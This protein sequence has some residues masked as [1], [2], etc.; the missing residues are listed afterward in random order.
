M[1]NL[2][3]LAFIASF[4]SLKSQSID[5]Y[6]FQR[7]GGITNKNCHFQLSKDTFCILNIIN[8]ISSYSYNCI[9]LTNANT[10]EN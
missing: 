5:G 6:H 4:L 8:S 3:L 1:K 9:A 10:G 2:I 7:N